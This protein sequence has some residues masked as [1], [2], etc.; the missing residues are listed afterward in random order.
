MSGDMAV[1]FD[2]RHHRRGSMYVVVLGASTA[3]AVIGLAALTSLRIN[4][5][6]M[7]LTSDFA[8][9]RLYA[10]SAIEIGM[11]RIKEDPNWRTT[12]PLLPDDVWELDQ[13]IGSGTYT[14]KGVDP[15]D[16]DFTNN[17]TDPLVLTGIGMQGEARCMLQVTLV[18]KT[19]PLSCLEVSLQAGADAVFEDPS[20]VWG[21][22][23]ISAN[24]VIQALGA[25]TIYPNCE[26]VNG[27]VGAVQP[28]SATSGITPREMPD[29][30]TVFEYYIANGTQ[31]TPPD[32][33]I[34]KHLISPASNPFG[35]TTNPQGIYVINCWGADLT[36]TKS[37]IVGTLVILNPGP[38]SEIKPSVHWEAA[39]QNFPALLVEGGIRMDVGSDPLTESSAINFNPPGTPYE[40]V[41]DGDL[42]DSYEAII[43][44][45][46]Y[47]SDSLQMVNTSV[48]EGALVVGGTSRTTGTLTLIYSQRYLTDHPPGFGKQLGMDVSPGT[49]RQ[50]VD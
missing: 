17:D 20:T 9:A 25:C 26:A 5:H 24:N 33:R 38:N 39:L 22:Q 37:R 46:V 29:P 31:I 14:L 30:L 44:G 23:I 43:T 13:P 34:D 50:V 49:W 27:F 16:A 28:G 7:E 6:S 4:R 40:G 41:E 2:K 18:A 11:F 10:R 48:I 21:E 15:D 42:D 12:Y 19:A 45:L 36:I 35:P 1:T 32:Y 47:V 8:D 3:I